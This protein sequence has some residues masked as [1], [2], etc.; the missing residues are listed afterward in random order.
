MHSIQISYVAGQPRILTP[1]TE[2]TNVVGNKLESSRAVYPQSNIHTTGGKIRANQWRYVDFDG[3]GAV[4]LVVGVGDW[5]DYGWDN[6]FNAQGEWTRG[7]LHGYVYWLKNTGTT[8]APSYAEAERVLAAGI[9]VDVFGMPS[10]NFADFDQDGDLD[11]LCGEFLDGFTYFQ[12]IGSRQEPRYA[13]GK[14]LTHDGQAITMELQ[15]ITPTAIDWDRDGDIDLIVGDE[16]GRVAWIEHTGEVVDGMPQFVPPRYFQQ[17]AADL[18]FGALVTPVSVDWDHDGDEDLVCGNSA[19]FIALIENL[20]GGDPP[21]WSVPQRFSVGDQPLRV[22]AGPN[23]SIQGPAEAKWGYTTLSVADWDGDQHWDLIVNSIWGRVEWYRG[24]PNDDTQVSSAQPIPLAS[25]TR[26]PKPAWN[27]WTAEP[28]ELV[29]QWRT[30]PVVADWDRDG[31]SDLIMLDHEG[32]LAWFRGTMENGRHVVQPGERRFVDAQRQP[33]QLNAGT[34]GKS[35]RRKL[36]IVD[37]DGDGR[38]DI[39]VNGVNAQWLRQIAG[40]EGYWIFEDRGALSDHRLAGHTTSPTPIDWDR[41][42]VRDLLIGA[43]DGFFYYLGNPTK[44]G[45]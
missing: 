40:E 43:E 38:Q 42:G 34:A 36:C 24:G 3:D 39:V 9:A 20:D 12:N 33:L 41:N 45:L 30:T 7:P 19:G 10:P 15:M 31:V 27:W 22:Q 2:W 21:R 14:R 11:L 8:D 16:D 17:Q 13:A 29:T 28:G 5:E 4:D 44:H 6:A 35:G 25:G 32:Y 23:G 1:A 37:W 18:K 26:Q